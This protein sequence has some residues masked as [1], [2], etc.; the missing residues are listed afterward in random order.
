MYSAGGL[1]AC[2]AYPRRMCT[3][4]FPLEGGASRFWSTSVQA[5]GLLWSIH[6]KKYRNA[7]RRQ[8]FEELRPYK[9]VALIAFLACWPRIA[10]GMQGR[11]PRSA[12]IRTVLSKPIVHQWLSVNLAAILRI[13]AAM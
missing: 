9:P 10:P 12:S 4:R 13:F 11:L 1:N 5:R 2:S 8:I 6:S 7:D 3:S